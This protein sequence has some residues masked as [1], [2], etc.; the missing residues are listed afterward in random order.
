MSNVHGEDRLVRR[1][2]ELG[3]RS[4]SRPAQREHRAAATTAGVLYIVGTVAGIFSKVVAYFPVL[5]QVND[6]LATGYLIIR[7][8]VE[9]VIYVILAIVLLLLVPLGETMT[10]GSGTNT[11][12]GVRLGLLV[13]DADGA[14]R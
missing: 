1:E 10:A 4:Q 9:T 5:R 14:S 2:E 13:I 7:G 12:A 6:L 8:A 3:D 11:P